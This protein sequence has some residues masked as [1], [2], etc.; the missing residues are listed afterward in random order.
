MMKKKWIA[1]TLACLMSVTALSGCGGGSS[2]SG[3]TETTAFS[4]TGETTATDTSSASAEFTF[5]MG[6][7]P[8]T[9]DV[10]MC[11]DAAT[12]R[13]LLQVHET[14]YKWDET[15]ENVIPWLVESSEEAEDGLSW[16]FKLK[17]GIKFHDGTNFNAEA[18]KYNFDRLV[19]PE[20]GSSKASALSGV[21]SVEAVDEYTVKINLSGRNL[22]FEQTLT[23][24]STA[25]M[26]PTACETYGL[27]GY[28][29]HPSGTGPLKMESWE[30]GVQ[31][32]L[33]KNEDYWGEEPTTEKLIVKA[34]SED[35]SRVMMAKTGDAD[36]SWGISPALVSSLEGDENVVVNTATG[37]RTI[38]IAM[39]QSYGPLADSRVRAAICYA[40]NKG[41]IVNNILCGVGGTYPSGYESSAVANSAKDLDPYEQDLEKARELLTEAGYPDGFNIKLNTPEGRYAMDRQTAEAVQYMLAQIGINAE[42]EVLEWGTYQSVM[43]EKK[44]TQLF[45][46]GKG[47][48]TGDVEFDFLMHVLS[49]GGQN[50]YCINNTEVDDILNNLSSAATQEERGEML[51]EAQ[52]IV[53]DE[54]DF[55]TLYYENQIVATRAD[56]SGLVIYSNETADLAWLTR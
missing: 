8:T 27:D 21:E 10:H 19:A 38:Y 35:S 51:Y 7:E 50:Y 41:E 40:I 47:S 46:L 6:T 14:L 2:S 33:V 43:S 49:T 42:I 3:S 20:T 4:N 18:V 11:T 23:N 56:V 45:L 22:I 31:M 24:Y 48:S 30:P 12:S 34:V 29:N 15:S 37:Y 5:V 55:A 39:N 13:I 53:N 54:Y 28:T 1:L 16:T 36:I 9:M 25:I 44:E 32:T 26:S 52:K 17:E